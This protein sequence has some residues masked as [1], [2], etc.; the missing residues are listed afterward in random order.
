MLGPQAPDP[1]IDLEVLDIVKNEVSSVLMGSAYS[2][3]LNC[4]KQNWAYMSWE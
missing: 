1:S 2:V 3:L 4:S